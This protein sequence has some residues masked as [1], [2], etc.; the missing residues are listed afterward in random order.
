VAAAAPARAEDK[1]ATLSPFTAWLAS[2]T[3]GLMKKGLWWLYALLLL[4]V[5]VTVVLRALAR[6]RNKPRA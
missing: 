6:G 5:A 3:E 4:V 2:V 1:S